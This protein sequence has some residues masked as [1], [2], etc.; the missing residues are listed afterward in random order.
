[1]ALSNRDFIDGVRSS[2]KHFLNHLNDLTGEQIGWKPFPECKSIAETINHLV[3]D[4]RAALQSFQTGDEPDYEGLAVEE[5]D[6]NKLRMMLDASHSELMNYL[7]QNFGDAPLD[8]DATVWGTDLP[9]ARAIAYLI[10]ED[11]YHAGQVAFIRMAIDPDWDY[12]TEI[13]S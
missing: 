5:T 2:R 4:D 13:Y 6:Y 10:S 3:T 7:D 9:A 8:A 12:Y 1:M 11:F